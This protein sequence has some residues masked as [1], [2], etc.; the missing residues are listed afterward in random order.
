MLSSAVRRAAGHTR[1]ATVKTAA[2]LV[3]LALAGCA[4]TTDPTELRGTVGAAMSRQVATALAGGE[5]TFT[6]NSSTGG[7]VMSAALITGLLNGAGASLTVDG[8]CYSACAMLFVGTVNKHVGSDA[9]VQIHGAY[10]RDGEGDDAK[11]AYDSAEYLKVNGLP[12]AHKWEGPNGH[13]LT[14]E[15][16]EKTTGGRMA[17]PVC[18]RPGECRTP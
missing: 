10:W 8:V 3:A 15:E 11:A 4:A 5:R 7:Y 17:G 12:N 16:L 2:M 18:A 9:D 13:R 1:E 14:A 6:I